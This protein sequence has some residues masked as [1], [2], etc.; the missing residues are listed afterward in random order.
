MPSPIRGNSLPTF[1]HVADI[2]KELIN[3]DEPLALQD[4]RREFYDVG[5][6]LLA[7]TSMASKGPLLLRM[8]QLARTIQSFQAVNDV[9]PHAQRLAAGTINR[10][11]GSQKSAPKS[12]PKITSGRPEGSGNSVQTRSLSH[13][14]LL[15]SGTPK[16][17]TGLAMLH[18]CRRSIAALRV[19]QAQQKMVGL[20][21]SALLLSPARRSLGQACK[22]FVASIRSF[23]TQT[24]N[25]IV[26]R[27]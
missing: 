8:Q 2:R 11:V 16:L 13:H 17:S 27:M 1:Q 24:L 3:K 26:G 6:K 9:A 15:T 10:A 25:P 19:L 20:Q 14:A 21:R 18:A 12:L 7:A 23:F 22:Q 4:L 5:A